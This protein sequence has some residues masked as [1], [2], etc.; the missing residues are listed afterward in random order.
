MSDVN[1]NG[2]LVIG[3]RAKGRRSPVDGE[4]GQRY[5][6]RNYI[7]TVGQGLIAQR[8]VWHLV[9]V[10]SRDRPDWHN[11]KLYLDQKARKNLFHIGVCKGI[12]N[13]NREVAILDEHYPDVKEWARAQA[14]LYIDGK[15]SI[16]PER[17]KKVVYRKG[18]GWITVS[19]KKKD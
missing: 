10:P 3:Q 1:D 9:A 17:G 6:S 7:A 18:F 16:V 2:Q 13:V 14:C 19:K 11:F 4:D 15:I 5:G 12:V 8:G